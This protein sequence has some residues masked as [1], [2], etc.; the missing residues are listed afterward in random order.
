MHKEE[1]LCI[2]LHPRDCNHLAWSRITALEFDLYH[3]SD[4]CMSLFLRM[5]RQSFVLSLWISRTC[6]AWCMWKLSTVVK[7]SLRLNAC[8]Q[9][10][11][12]LHSYI[13]G[14]ICSRLIMPIHLMS[15]GVFLECRKL[16]TMSNYEK[17]TVMA[18]MFPHFQSLCYE[19]AALVQ[20][21]D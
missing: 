9:N 3:A 1:N 10:P 12:I 7:V 2:Y 17:L 15:C 11:I 14:H 6:G 16:P 4:K 8:T 13:G 5:Y 19:I 21:F 18:H 20:L